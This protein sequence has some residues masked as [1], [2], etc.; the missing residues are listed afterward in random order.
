MFYKLFEKLETVAS[1]SRED[2][3]KSLLSHVEVVAKKRAGNLIKISNHKQEKLAN[4]EPPR[5]F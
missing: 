3:E 4:K 2:A 1:L 5:L